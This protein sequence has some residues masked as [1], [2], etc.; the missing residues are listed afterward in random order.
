MTRG[1]DVDE[2]WAS[3]RVANKS[4]ITSLY[5]STYDMDTLIELSCLLRASWNT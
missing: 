1:L 2:V 5:I 4:Y 3:G